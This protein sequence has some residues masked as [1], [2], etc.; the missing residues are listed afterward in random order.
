LEFGVR[1]LVA[2]LGVFGRRG[3]FPKDLKAVTSH[4]TPNLECGDLSLWDN[5]AAALPKIL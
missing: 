5:F 3:R 2:A 1:R 4:S